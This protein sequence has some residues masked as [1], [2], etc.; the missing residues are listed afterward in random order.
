LNCVLALLGT[1]DLLIPERFVMVTR[2]YDFSC[3]KVCRTHRVNGSELWT[4]TVQARDLPLGFKYG[5]NARYAELNTKAAKDMLE[6]LENDPGSF[7]FKN[8]GIMV[9]AESIKSEGTDVSIVCKRVRARGRRAWSR[10]SERW[11]LLQG[12]AVR[13]ELE[14]R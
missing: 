5:P 10:R 4:L 6:T 3:Q 8:N 9:V 14:R 1:W 7:I 13:P 11:P 12:P 2:T